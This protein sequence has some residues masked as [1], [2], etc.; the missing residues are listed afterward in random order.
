V[1]PG[2][3]GK[4]SIYNRSGTVNIRA[5][6]AGFY[7]T[8]RAD[9]AG[10][11]YLPL[12]AAHAWD[13][14]PVAA[15]STVSFKV[16]GRGGAPRSG[17]SAV[18][19]ELT[20]IAPSATGRLTVYPAGKAR[21]PLAQM[22]TTAGQTQTTMTIVRPGAH[23][24]VSIYNQAGSV[25]LRAETV[26]YLRAPNWVAAENARKGTAAWHL[27]RKG[28]SD[29]IQG[30]ADRTSVAPGQPFGLHVETT[31]ARWR[32]TAFRV[33]WYHGTGARRVWS[34]NWHKRQSQP[35]AMTSSGTRTI[36]A[37]WHRSATISPDGWPSG[38]Y[39]LK[40]HSSAGNERYVPIT[41][42]SPSTHSRMVLMNEDLTWQAYNEWGGRDL[43]LG[44]NGYGDRSYIVSFD[45]PYDR[46]GA[47]KFQEFEQALITRAER[48][49]LNMAY[50]TDIYVSEHPNSI[51][52]ARSVLSPGHDEYWTWDERAA[53]L[54]ARNHG[55]N[56]A[57][58]G[59]N[60]QY[61]QVRLK[62]TSLGRDRKIICYKTDVARDPAARSDPERETTLWRDLPHPK[63]ESALVGL[64]YE[65]YPVEGR[66]VV[67]TP[68]FFAFRGTGA[69]RGSSYPGLV[70]LEIDRARPGGATPRNLEVVAHSP[71]QCNGAN[72]YSDTS[73]YVAHSQAGVFATGT[74]RWTQAL[75]GT[76]RSYGVT[77]ATIKFVRIATDNIL[78]A[79][80]LGPAGLRHKPKA[81]LTSLDESHPNQ[82]TDT[83]YSPDPRGHLP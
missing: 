17:V 62:S 23:G 70:G 74:M 81:N 69:K 35:A 57:F 66:Y 79:F 67:R 83:E 28:P 6:V 40:L 29:A 60:A 75:A 63:P 44:P 14:G 34:S 19:L 38:S 59:A 32:V 54:R 25:N 45:R 26:G 61:W 27:H 43:Y 49:G 58:F 39:L 1:R 24:N 77:Q 16:L 10:A 64:M 53:V 12:G 33:G 46:S 21:P 73:Y 56:L 42:R 22:S 65:C 9:V 36:T 4:V 7:A 5:D 48:L 80:A 31:A 13:T 3:R 72:T 37:P 8:A 30:F 20:A 15:G 18:V 41:V 51:A 2:A 82:A 55:A 52:H 11:T 76:M 47:Y 78:R 50:T 71:V 68:S